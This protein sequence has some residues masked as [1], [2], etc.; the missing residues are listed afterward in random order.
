MTISARTLPFAVLFCALLWGSAF[1]GIKAIFSE[2][3]RLGIESTFANRVLLAGV[4]FSF[5]G[6][7]LLLMAKQP[8]KQWQQTA[9]GPLLLFAATQTF[10]Q[11]VFFYTGL[12]V[13]SAVMG[14]LL[15][16]TGSL[17]W[18]VLAPIL[19]KSPWPNRKQWLLIALGACGVL[20]AVYKPGA[21]S[22]R[23][24]LGAVLFCL[25]T[26]SGSIGVIVL[27]KVLPTMGARAA[28]GFGLLL[29]GLMLVFTG[30]AAW[31]EIAQLFSSKVLVIT[32]YLTLVSAAAF[33][34]WN[35]LTQLFPVNLLAGY[36][37]LIPICAV[38]ESSLLVAG[39]SPGIGIWLGGALVLSSVIALQQSSNQESSKKRPQPKKNK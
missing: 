29:G 8:W 22:G 5:A 14:G 15:V 30:V 32:A 36:R 4:R 39:E 27:Q 25:S 35:H 26:L 19:L 20:F 18:L 23:P 12:A 6:V 28:T 7:L 17:W 37:F 2:W 21:G 31:P 16:S 3:E 10:I 1:P 9:K 24:V 33:G 11:Y 34:L 38:I 13:S